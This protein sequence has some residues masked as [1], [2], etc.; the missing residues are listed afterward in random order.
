MSHPTKLLLGNVP[1]FQCLCGHCYSSVTL[2]AVL[3]QY[4]S[5]GHLYMSICYYVQFVFSFYDIY[6]LALNSSYEVTYG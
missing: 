6:L 2:C 5:V 4:A 1:L 3:R